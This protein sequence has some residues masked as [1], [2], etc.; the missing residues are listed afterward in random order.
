MGS[1]PG[2]ISGKTELVTAIHSDLHTGT[3]Y[4][5]W[6]S[7][8]ER[9][10][11]VFILDVGDI[12]ATGTVDLEIQQAQDDAGTG[13]VAIAAKSIT[14]LTQA[15][16]DGNDD[17]CINLG[18][19]ELDAANN[20]C[21]VRARLDCLTASANACLLVLADALRYLPPSKANWTEEV[22]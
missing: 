20:F 4:T 19:A 16:G 14:Q 17:V 6:L 2:T 5:N 22:D 7:M 15:G 21:Y 8:A 1:Y 9:A 10:R 12:T 3:Y 18:G 13:A 11:L